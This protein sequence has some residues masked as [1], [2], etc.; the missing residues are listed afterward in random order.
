MTR[1]LRSTLFTLAA[2]AAMRALQSQT[3]TV[4]PP[5]PTGIVLA[6]SIERPKGAR[7]LTEKDF[8]GYL[9]V[10]LKDQTQAAYLA[11]SH[12]GYTFTDVNSGQPVF[13]GVLLAG[14]KGIRDPH[15]TRGP[16]GAFYLVMTDLHTFAQRLGYRTTQW[17][18]PQEQYGGATIAPSS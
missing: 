10:Y 4:A 2:F 3:P 12:D 9:L 14:Q 8:A 15:I 5:R 11:I 13:N 7:N 1:A 18:R 16:D 6:D 17:E